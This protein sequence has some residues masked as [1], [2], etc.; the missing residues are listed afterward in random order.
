MGARADNGPESDR[1]ASTA[2][3]GRAEWG[4]CRGGR[5]SLLRGVRYVILTAVSA[6]VSVAGLFPSSAGAADGD[7]RITTAYPY[8]NVQPGQTVSFDIQVSASTPKVVALSV[9]DVPNG[10]KATLRGGGFVIDGITAST[11]PAKPATATL[12]IQVPAD[13][14]AGTYPVNVFGD[15]AVAIAL[16]LKVAATV[17]QGVELTAD[18][19][20][21]KK[22]PSE[23]FD[24]TITVNNNVPVEQVFNFEATGP[25]GWDVTAS[26]ASEA[27]APNVRVAG[28]GTGKAKISA[29]AAP[30]T[31]GG[32]YPIQ[33]VVRSDKGGEGS[34]TLTA[35]VAG[36]AQLALST[37]DQRLNLSA[38]A[39]KTVRKTLV[40]RNAG[41]AA[42]E[43]VSLSASTPSDWKVTF[44]PATVASVEAGQT[45][46]VT[47]VI[48][49]SKDAV[50]GDYDIKITSSSGGGLSSDASLRVTVKSS[51]LWGL[52]GV[53][54]I[55]VAVVALF[56]LFRRFGRR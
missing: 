28:G 1:R 13:T 42:L 52:V 6:V 8:V 36:A 41:S 38:Q 10:W 54:L 56:S 30:D 2:R 22:K 12:E 5:D 7:V 33:V 47:A 23:S 16:Q 50:A 55:V 15:G 46:P 9:S 19:D 53:A 48:R 37:S 34:I 3:H 32:E 31:A 39:G 45:V 27:A 18:F 4:G 20:R 24:F 44:E 49:P 35:I 51:R 25:Q 29:K 21:L 40:V 14:A 26:N 43:N 11:D 17:A